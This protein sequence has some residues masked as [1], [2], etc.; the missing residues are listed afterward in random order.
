MFANEIIVGYRFRQAVGPLVVFISGKRRRVVPR[1]ASTAALPRRAV[2]MGY[3]LPNAV[4][5]RDLE[6][7]GRRLAFID[8]T[9]MTSQY[10]C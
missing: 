3:S 6:H 4:I 7:F 2:G 10:I 5:N 1:L 8:V 9:F